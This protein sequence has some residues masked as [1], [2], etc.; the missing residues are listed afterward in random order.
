MR[1]RWLFDSAP[2]RVRIV[3]IRVL[4]VELRATT[5]VCVSVVVLLVARVPDR[6]LVQRAVPDDEEEPAESVSSVVHELKIGRRPRHLLK[7]TKR[8]LDLLY[9]MPAATLHGVEESVSQSVCDQLSPQIRLLMTAMKVPA[10]AAATPLRKDSF[11][12]TR[13]MNVVNFWT[14]MN[15]LNEVAVV[16][17]HGSYSP[18]GRKVAH[19][20]RPPNPVVP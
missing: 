17:L 2:E 11:F 14:M 7:P 19:G 12:E 13:T 4:L 8:E 3:P 16:A 5:V 20:T 10:P 1:E 6:E 15:S 9:R 18:T